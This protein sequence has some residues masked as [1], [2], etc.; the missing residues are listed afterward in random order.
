MFVQYYVVVVVV[1]VV[2]VDRE[3]GRLNANEHDD[4]RRI[5]FWRVHPSRVCVCVCLFSRR[6]THL[7]LEE[8]SRFF[9]TWRVVLTVNCNRIPEKTGNNNNDLFALLTV[10]G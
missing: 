8:G 7:R 6:W 2:C 10:A 4:D 3:S 5:F 9:A 1:V